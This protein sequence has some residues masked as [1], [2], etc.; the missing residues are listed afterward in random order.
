E[1]AHVDPQVVALPRRA[2]APDFLQELA[3]GED[4]PR[5]L[6]ERREEV[7]LGPRKVDLFLAEEDTAG[8]EVHLQ[9]AGR[10]NRFTLAAGRA[11][12]V[13]ERHAHPGEQLTGS[14]RLGQVVVGAGVQG[15]DIVRLLATRGETDDQSGALIAHESSA[16]DE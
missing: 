9:L 7:V 15:F 6:D 5:V 10:K 14:E 11:R 3:M 16:L 13:A 12:G 2:G 1:L 8:G 4:L